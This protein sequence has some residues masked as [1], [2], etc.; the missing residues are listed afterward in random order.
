MDS[1]LGLALPSAG[2]STTASFDTTNLPLAAFR[3]EA[4]RPLYVVQTPGI[5]GLIIV[6]EGQ[7]SMQVRWPDGGN[8]VLQQNSS[9]DRG[10]WT[11]SGYSVSTVNGTNSIT[12][13]APT[14]NV[15]F[16]LSKP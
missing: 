1:G 10:N 7:N 15:F 14:G 2:P 4:I 6:R 11:A 8:F 13:T 9:L 5:P 16:R 12:I 3:V